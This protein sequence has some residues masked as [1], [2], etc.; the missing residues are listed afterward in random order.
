MNEKTS[1]DVGGVLTYTGSMVGVDF[2]Q[3]NVVDIAVQCM[4]QCRFAGA[5]KEWWPV[6]M[7]QMLTADIM[8]RVL[9]HTDLVL[10]CLLHDAPEAIFGDTPTPVKTAERRGQENNLQARIYQS[11]NI[12]LPTDDQRLAI[13]EADTLAL[14]AEAVVLGS[15]SF[16]SMIEER[17]GSIRSGMDKRIHSQ[18]IMAELYRTFSALDALNAKGQ[19]V[20]DYRNRVFAE[21]SYRHF[22]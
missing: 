19:H 5:L 6:G 16:Y 10:D 7:H 18:R 15:P 20:A 9:H 21:I 12:K 11:L 2:G 14:I 22:E 13:K 8:D 3:P 1:V 4:R 17:S